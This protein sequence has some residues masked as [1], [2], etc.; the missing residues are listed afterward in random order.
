[1]I[2]LSI[3]KSI[4]F[5]SFLDMIHALKATS[6]SI[7]DKLKN[8]PEQLFFRIF[9]LLPEAVVHSCSIIMLL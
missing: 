2:L 9:L 6:S 4:F 7:R 3:F 1:M 8:F 5:Y